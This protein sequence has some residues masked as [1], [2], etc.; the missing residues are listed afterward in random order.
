MG[1][2]GEVM[3]ETIIMVGVVGNFILQLAWWYDSHY[4]HKKKDK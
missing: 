1:T 4:I 2:K 3:V